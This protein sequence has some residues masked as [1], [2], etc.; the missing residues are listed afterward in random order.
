VKS[1]EVSK[2]EKEI[3]REILDWLNREPH[4]FAYKVNTVGVWDEKAQAHRSLGKFVLKGTSDILGIW[5]GKPMAI[6]VKT[7]S[8]KLSPEQR[9]FIAKYSEMGGVAFRADSVESAQMRLRYF[10]KNGANLSE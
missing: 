7:P 5:R 6:E 3:E 9:A 10:D 2:S 4:C 8:G 1:T